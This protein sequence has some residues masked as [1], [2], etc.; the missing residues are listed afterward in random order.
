V[1]N[2]TTPAPPIIDV[3]PLSLISNLF[4]GEVDTHTVTISN[5]G[6]SDLHYQVSQRTVG[7]TAPDHMEQAAPAPQKGEKDMRTGSPVLM[8]QGQ[9][10]G[11]YGY[12]WIDSNEPAGPTFD[13]IDISATG[14]S[15]SLSDDSYQ[16]VALPFDFEFYREIKNEL[17]ISS[18][19]FV[20]FS[21]AGASSFS[22]TSLPSPG[23]PNDLIALMWTDMN[24]S[25]GG[26][27][28]YLSE[29]TRFI[30]QYDDVP[31]FGVGGGYT[32]QVILYDNG[33]IKIQYLSL[34]TPIA[35]Y[36]TGIENSSGTDALQVAFNT[37]YIADNLAV[38]ITSEQ[39]LEVTIDAGPGVVGAGESVDITVEVDAFQLEGGTYEKEIIV[40]SNDPIT[41]NV[42]VDL[43][44]N[45]TGEA[46]ITLG[47]TALDFGEVFL[48]A[49]AKDSVLISNNGTDVLTI[50]SITNS[51]ADYTTS[52]NTL[53]LNAGDQAYLVVD[54][55]PIAVG[56]SVDVVT[57]SSDDPDEGVVTIDV[58]GEGVEQPII[59]VVPGSLTADLLTGETATQTLTI[60]NTGGSALDF[61]LSIEN[62]IV[63]LNLTAKF[64]IPERTMIGGNSIENSSDVQV[65]S[66]N[67]A[68]S[69]EDPSIL[70]I[71]N[72]DSWGTQMAE[73]IF[74]Q[75]AIASEVIGYELIET[76]DFNNY[77]IIITVGDESSAYYQELSNQVTKFEDFVNAGGI[78]QY[79][80][81]TQGDDV[82][83]VGGV[84][85]IFGNQENANLV[86]DATHPLTTGLPA[87]L[88]GSSANHTFFTNLTPSTG[89]ISETQNSNDP[90]TIEYSYGQGTVI[91]TGMTWGY[92]VSSGLDAGLMM[93]NSLAYV[94]ELSAVQQFISLGTESGTIVAGDNELID[95]EF[96]ASG[97]YG[98]VYQAEIIVQS[99]DPVMSEVVVPV[100]LNVQGAP[101]VQL[102][103][104][105]LDFE[106]VFVGGSKLDSL[107]ISNIGSD[108]LTIATINNVDGAYETSIGSMVLNPNEETYLVVEFIPA[109]LGS[110]ADVITIVSDDPD[111]PSLTVD[112]I[113]TGIDPPMIA[114]SPS[115]LTSNLLSEQSETQ[116]IT[117]TN[118]GSAD[119]DYNLHL[120]E[121][122]FTVT[123]S[124]VAKSEIFNGVKNPLTKE[125]APKVVSTTHKEKEFLRT[126]DNDIVPTTTNELAEVLDELN[127]NYNSITSLVPDL[128]EFLDGAS[129][130]AISDGGNDMYDQGNLLSTNLGSYLTYTNGVISASEIFNNE[131]Y[132]TAKYPGLFVMVADMSNVDYFEITGNLGADGSGSVDGVVLN[133][134][135][136]GTSYYGFVKRVFNAN[137]PSVNHMIIVE[138]NASANHE[139]STSTDNDQ[140]KVLDIDGITRIYYLLYASASGG[141]VDNAATMSIMER[142][143]ETV[144]RAK[145]IS[146]P[147]ATTGVLAAGESAN[148]DV[149]FSAIDLAPG[150]YSADILIESND[151][152]ASELAV[153]VVLNVMGAPELRLSDTSIDFGEILK[154]TS[155]KDS[156]LISNLGD[157]EL[158]ISSISN[159]ATSYE[160]TISTLI[161]APSE[162]SY[163]VV[164][165][166]PSEIGGIDDVI[167]ISSNDPNQPVA[168]VNV[169]GVGTGIPLLVVDPISLTANLISGEKEGQSLTFDNVEG[170]AP[171]E[172][173]NTVIEYIT[174]D[175]W[176]SI[177]QNAFTVAEGE[178]LVGTITFDAAS[179]NDGSYEAIILIDSNDPD[180]PLLEIPISLNV[181]GIPAIEVAESTIDFGDVFVGGEALMTMAVHNAG[182]VQLNIEE[183]SS[184]S[185][186]FTIGDYPSSLGI[187]ESG[188]VDVYYKPPTTGASSTTIT[189]VSNDPSTPNYEVV[190]TGN[191]VVAPIL[192]VN[193][194]Q[195]AEALLMG[196][197]ANQTIEIS[198]IGSNNLIVNH[199][200]IDYLFGLNWLSIDKDAFTVIG[201]S[202]I[203][204]NIGFDA[205]N[206]ADGDY[207]ATI[208]FH[209]NDPITPVYVVSVSLQVCNAL[210]NDLP[211]VTTALNL[212]GLDLNQPV[213]EFVLSDYF[214]DANNDALVYTASTLENNIVIAEING[215]VL[216]INPVAVGNDVITLTVEDGNC[217]VLEVGVVVSVVDEV[218]AVSD[219]MKNDHFEMHNYPNPFTNSTTIAYFVDANGSS[220][221]NLTVY[222][223]QGK[224]ITVLVDGMQSRGAQY[225][226]FNTTDMQSGIYLYQLNVNGM[227]TVKRMMIK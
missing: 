129:G 165:F 138:N 94:I 166:T 124:V 126:K 36:V 42:T 41:P 10:S 189:I 122:E 30:V 148:V 37:A 96:D 118:N 54:F 132:F 75:F 227:V 85:T 117:I 48:G 67:Q 52:I 160:S 88:Q 184:T 142:F 84:Q 136:S 107:L 213:H 34:N 133:A 103:T 201:G 141:Y 9:D 4:T 116:Q 108:V 175:G 137:D 195:F 167:T 80:L 219:V 172:V 79:Q 58:T 212:V 105:S 207:E 92:L 161:L 90:T 176:L 164:E 203:V 150:V 147:N 11:D 169:S 63:N 100:T 199:T 163:L 178:Q 14:T 59:D 5:N 16:T 73:E 173:A 144:A 24:P 193:Q 23:T 89:T 72:T 188:M 145:G 109:S 61:A 45:I 74:T 31:L 101:D 44:V 154:G 2:F 112:L 217:G 197:Q 1:I 6:A 156:V 57:I 39:Q 182:T 168:T 17:H 69:A 149:A 179:L 22:T 82:D 81:A 191:G 102:S 114:V 171:L 86:V 27:I 98:G 185:S 110:I 40:S 83:I 170:E 194:T 187:G 77:D 143:I 21:P 215:G 43:T 50:S 29:A 210:N 216:L 115:S 224:L 196:E 214:A 53:Q 19:G 93:Y 125:E 25:S 91:A 157:D 152:I 204:G 60:H 198:N 180:N 130:I 46:D 119:L 128:Y 151:P 32:F 26:N 71:Q 47:A 65:N 13:W 153:P 76:T 113:G 8:G 226:T 99:N 87:I 35:S 209:S 123:S 20:S 186:E 49:T 38:L 159:D 221:V 205:T 140:H 33:D 206:I 120:A 146:L 104:T 158:I 162:A 155:K 56:A 68:L 200:T 223:L 181:T 211:E 139:F 55:S 64:N 106:G 97:L 51:H 174:G 95:V 192:S 7:V 131:E 111:Q 28:Y 220:K 66:F 225:V 12:A 208:T 15:V 78:V 222:S 183:M 177:D 190:L 3:T 127:T 121:V 62:V 135:Q 18:N 218:T 70:V 202:Q 134:Q